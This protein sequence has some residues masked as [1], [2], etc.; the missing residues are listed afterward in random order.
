MERGLRVDMEV[1]LLRSSLISLRLVGKIVDVGLVNIASGMD[2]RRLRERSMI[3][4]EW[5]RGRSLASFR[6]QEYDVSS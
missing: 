4:S 5:N 3:L 1:K 2:E 6:K